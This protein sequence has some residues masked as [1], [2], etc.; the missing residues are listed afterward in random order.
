MPQYTPR[1]RRQ[2]ARRTTPSS[3]LRLSTRFDRQ[4]NKVGTARPGQGSLAPQKPRTGQRSAPPAAPKP[5]KP[6]GRAAQPDSLYHGA[7]D[8]ANR[9][10]SQRLGALDTEERSVRH[11]F[12]IDDPTNPFS[13]AEGLKR[14]FLA[15]Q[16]AASVS[17]ASEG[18]LYS[19]AHERALARTRREEEEARANLRGAYEQAIGQIGATKAGVKFDTEEQKTQAFEDWLARAPEEEPPPAAQAATVPSTPRREG[20]TGPMPNNLSR[21][22]GGK[23][24]DEAIGKLVQDLPNP[25]GG[26]SRDSIA[27]LPGDNSLAKGRKENREA[28]LRRRLRQQKRAGN[29][30]RV[31]IL[32]RKIRKLNS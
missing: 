28:L 22:L 3:R 20:G 10:Q 27:T 12:G 14:A 8:L 24:K 17:L 26:G 15:R 31:K 2:L 18:H 30:R 5:A 23:P 1:Q 4:N 29:T 11:E 21:M 19:G 32:R 13:R 16:K 6:V 9:V 25:K 7:V